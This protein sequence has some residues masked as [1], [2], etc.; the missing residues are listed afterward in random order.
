MTPT[1]QAQ[2][3]ARVDASSHHDGSHRQLLAQIDSVPP[4]N[5]RIDAILVPTARPD[6]YLHDAI[7][8]T[9]SLDC[10]LVTLC[11]KNASIDA[12]EKRARASGVKLLAIDITRL[13]AGILPEFETARIVAGTKYTRD[14]DLSLKRNLGLLLSHLIGW[15]KI[16]FLDDD[17][18]VP[19]HEYIKDAAHL[20]D[21]FT[22]VGLNNHG[23][24]DNSAVCH[25]FRETRGRQETFIGGGALAVSCADTTSFFPDIYNEDWFFLV[26]AV[27]NKLTAATGTIR[28][29]SYDPFANK[30]RARSEELG[31]CL[32]E[33]LFWLLDRGIAIDKANRHHWRRFL[34]L[35]LK[36][37]NET[38][39]RARDL[40]W[41]APR[42]ARLMSA[43]RAARRTSRSITPEFCLGYLNAWHNDGTL[44]KEHL[45]AMASRVHPLPVPLESDTHQFQRIAAILSGLKMTECSRTTPGLSPEPQLRK[46]SKILPENIAGFRIGRMPSLRRQN[47]R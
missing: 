10:T 20:L 6:T 13:P 26:T 9:A 37:I 47:L 7:G 45:D 5:A 4:H 15:K 29:Q 16:F 25:A 44:W 30:R 12:A 3:L 24:P 2:E 28:H 21:S 39:K 43:L 8:L 31:D 38:I 41:E 46:I 33:G 40:E 14:C 35:R 19:N 17:I 22:A 36:F 18:A 42:K 32:A 34:D 27:A 11:S 23:Y 1:P